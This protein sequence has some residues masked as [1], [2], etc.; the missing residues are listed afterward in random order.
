MPLGHID[1]KREMLNV[2]VLP[3]LV[4]DTTKNSVLLLAQWMKQAY[5]KFQG[6]KLCLTSATLAVL[7]SGHKCHALECAFKF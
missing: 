1:L 7:D 4:T 2:L 5:S 3:P 6:R